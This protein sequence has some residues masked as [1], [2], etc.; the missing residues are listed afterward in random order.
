[1][2]KYAVFRTK[3]GYC[4]IAGTENAL[5][6]TCLPAAKAS[7]VKAEL[8]HHY[9]DAAPDRIYFM[10]IQRRIADYFAGKAIEFGDDIPIDLTGFTP[11]QR[12]VLNAC[13]KVRLGKIASYGQLAGKLGRPAAARAVGNALAT[14]PLPLIIPCHRILRSDKN[15]GGFS[16]PG[17]K[18]LKARLLKHENEMA[19]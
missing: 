16:A 11:F 13:R 5:R 4:G 10:H 2:T 6:R 18:T 3:W 12:Q 14:N 9:H 1:M 7:M 8:T 19:K 15:L 17:G